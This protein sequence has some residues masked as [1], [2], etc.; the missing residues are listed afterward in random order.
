MRKTEYSE[1]EFM[2][3]RPGAS[4]ELRREPEDFEEPEN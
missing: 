2:V 4:P 1:T 3:S